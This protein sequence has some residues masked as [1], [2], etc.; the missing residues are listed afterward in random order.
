[1]RPS[2]FGSCHSRLRERK[3]PAVPRVM[4]RWSGHTRARDAASV[5]RSSRG[6]GVGFG[7]RARR[8]LRGVPRPRGAEPRR[9][10]RPVRSRLPVGLG[11][12]SNPRL[13]RAWRVRALGSGRGPGQ[14][15]RRRSVRRP[16]RRRRS[17][18][19][20]A[21]AHHDH[22]GHRETDK[23]RA[24]FVKGRSS[25]SSPNESAI[26]GKWRKAIRGKLGWIVR[27]KERGF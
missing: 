7:V 27:R 1:M 10:R 16:G 9:H 20:K 23:R 14:D 8:L 6:G 3:L 2:I 24:H 13:R 21:Q 18:H 4:R 17:R 15:H 25:A 22:G 19:A 26:T 5:E 11:A 12:Q